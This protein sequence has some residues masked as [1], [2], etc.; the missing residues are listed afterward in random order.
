M[1]PVALAVPLNVTV[2]GPDS[3][4]EQPLVLDLTTK[5][6]ILEC[7]PV[8]EPVPLKGSHWADADAEPLPVTVLSPTAVPDPFPRKVGMLTAPLLIRRAT[9]PL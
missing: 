2:T 1:P 5:R 7:A 9:V 3:P 4:L 8:I 6:S